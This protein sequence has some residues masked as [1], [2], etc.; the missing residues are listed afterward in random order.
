MTD[1]PPMPFATKRA[2]AS[3][4]ES[5]TTPATG[6]HDVDWEGPGS[7]T[8]EMTGRQWWR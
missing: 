3:A 2:T 6:T 7:R 8:Q 5:V 1:L 4:G